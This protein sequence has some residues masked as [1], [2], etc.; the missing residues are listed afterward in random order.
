MNFDI[1]TKNLKK[2]GFSVYVCQTQEDVQG[3]LLNK[4]I[5]P[6][7]KVV[8]FGNS[9]TLRELG[10]TDFIADYVE[11]VYIHN[12][13]DFSAENDRKAM[14]ADIYLTSANAISL[15]GCIVNIDGTGN[16]T[17]ATCFGP[18][19][20]VYVVGKNKIA[21]TMEGAIDKAKQAAANL[22]KFYG[23]NTPCAVTGKCEDCLSP[24]CICGVMTIHRKY[25][26]GNKISVIL[27]DADLG[28]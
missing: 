16:R 25:L 15:D 8:G 6:E 18:K 5:D 28:I 26:Y 24:E 9:K 19:Q 27:V 11:K 21:E 12:P 2:R 22:A 17:A 4:I 20:V 1:V 7:D 14:L 3:I 10:I 23:R 13:R